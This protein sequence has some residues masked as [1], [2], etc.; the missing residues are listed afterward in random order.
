[1]RKF[2]RKQRTR[3]KNNARVDTRQ[4]KPS[5]VG[6]HSSRIGQG[7]LVL[8]TRHGSD[9]AHSDYFQNKRTFEYTKTVKI[10]FGIITHGAI[11]SFFKTYLLLQSPC[12]VCARLVLSN[13]WKAVIRSKSDDT[14]RIHMTFQIFVREL[15]SECFSE[16]FPTSTLY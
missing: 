12:R 5:Q 14:D 7:A 11:L 15:P 9:F 10:V 2:S 16:S 8:Q 4:P 6:S 13:I 1:M 3:R